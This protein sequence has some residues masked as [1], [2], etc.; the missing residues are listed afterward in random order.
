MPADAPARVLL[1]FDAP[2][3]FAGQEATLCAAFDAGDVPPAAL[4][5]LQA[6]CARG[7]G[8]IDASLDT[9]RRMLAMVRALQP[10]PPWSAHALDVHTLAS[11]HLGADGAFRGRGRGF[12]GATRVVIAGL[13][14][15]LL[16]AG[17]VAGELLRHGDARTLDMAWC[18]ALGVGCGLLGWVVQEFDTP[19]QTR[20]HLVDR[21]IKVILVTIAC[22]IAACAMA[23]RGWCC[24][25]W[26]RTR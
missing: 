26:R 1:H 23:W 4:A 20:R 9:V 2:V 21:A 7:H 18:V 24:S 5:Q 25:S 16:L 14:M 19:D 11:W 3:D 8:P 13:A 10:V 6:A 22:G 15:P 17:P 12:G